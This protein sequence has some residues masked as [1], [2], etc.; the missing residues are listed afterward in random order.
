MNALDNRGL[1][2]PHAAG[3]EGATRQR[4]PWARYLRRPVG[5]DAVAMQQ[6]VAA[7]RVLDVNSTYA[8]LLIATDFAASSIVADCDGELCGL[9]TA[10]HPPARP[11][12]LFVWQVAVA[13]HAQGTG[14]AATML[15]A[16]V[17][18]V[19]RARHGHPVTVEATVAPG[20]RASRAFFSGFARRHG[21]PITE[22]SHFTADLLDPEGAHEDEPILRI[23]PI[24]AALTD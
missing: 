18:R 2:S 7:T 6:L 24:T 15:D 9:I 22:Q 11:E 5:A 21:V 16:L 17:D 8:Y 20:N 1:K 10:Y 12:V 13:E 23:G 14:L 4:V 3:A 19:R